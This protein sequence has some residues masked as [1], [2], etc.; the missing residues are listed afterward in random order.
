MITADD[1]G[2]TAVQ[3]GIDRRASRTRQLPRFGAAV[4]ALLCAILLAAEPAMA[5]IGRASCRERV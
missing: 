3:G 5:Q 1:D 2:S 4:G